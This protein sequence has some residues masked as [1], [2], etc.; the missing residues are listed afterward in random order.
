LL[1]AN[2]LSTVVESSP[3]LE[4]KTGVVKQPL[5]DYCE[6]GLAIADSSIGL[7][8]QAWTITANGKNIVYTPNSIGDATVVYTA[9]KDVFWVAGTFTQSMLPVIV[10]V[11]AD[12]AFLRWYDSTIP[13]YTVTDLPTGVTRPFACLDDNRALQLQSSDVI[14]SYIY[15]GNLCYRQQRDRYTIEYNLGKPPGIYQTQAGPNTVNRF[16]F[17]F[18]N[19]VPPP[20]QIALSWSDDGGLTWSQPRYLLVGQTGQYSQLVRAWRLGYGR[21]RAFKV[22]YTEP[23]GLSLFGADLKITVPPGTT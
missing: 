1:P 2:V 18:R 3:F 6:G 10:F 12:G 21:N 15:L 20:L 7:E 5:I 11:T 16:Q 9:D 22:T 4:P 19:V 14:V 17:E 23:T 8:V 13:G